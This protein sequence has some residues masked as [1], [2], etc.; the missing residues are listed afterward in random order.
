MSDKG[1]LNLV[2][3]NFCIGER[4]GTI[5]ANIISFPSIWHWVWWGKFL[6]MIFPDLT[7]ISK[8]IWI[9]FEF[10]IALMFIF[11]TNFTSSFCAISSLIHPSR[12]KLPS[13]PKICKGNVPTIFPPLHRE[14]ISKSF[15]SHKRKFSAKS[16]WLIENQ[17]NLQLKYVA[18]EV[19]TEINLLW[20]MEPVIL[21]I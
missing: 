14:I 10:E 13:S 16:R 1:K 3:E 5:F 2:Q 6:K 19:N 15:S 7:K 8:F 21:S 17:E 18:Q 9:K 12:K 20:L 11:H 4:E